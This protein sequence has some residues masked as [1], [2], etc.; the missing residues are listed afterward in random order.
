M[1]TKAQPAE[2]GPAGHRVFHTMDGLRGVAA[3]MV[4]S[5]HTGDWFKHA[6]P[7]SSYLAVDLFFA[8]SGFVISLSYEGRLK[9]GLGLWPFL[10]IRLIRLY[11][12]YLLGTVIALVA[13][14]AAAGDG[15]PARTLLGGLPA[16]LMLP[17]L[18]F[19]LDRPVYPMNLPAWSL[20]AELLV[21]AAFA[22]LVSSFSNRVL[23]IGLAVSAAGLVAVGVHYQ[24]LAIGSDA[25]SFLP[26]LLRTAYAFMA[27]MAAYRL[28]A[29]GRWRLPAA[30]SMT[31]LLTVLLLALPAPASWRLPYDLACALVLLPAIVAMAAGSEPGSRLAAV[32]SQLGGV[33]YAI[34]T[35]HVPIYDA[36]KRLG[37]RSHGLAA[38]PPPLSGALFLLVLLGLGFAADACFDRPVRRWLSRRYRK[39]TDS[40]G[41]AAT[42]TTPASRASR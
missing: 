25:G 4:V 36:L 40:Q 26:S 30:P 35:I 1:V 37:S 31:V 12:L 7:A 17:D 23:A 14:F 10:R 32:F 6:R 29:A 28:T 21:N 18:A 38:L 2:A 39:P 19:Q 13:A 9:A 5:W 3:L 22:A 42:S 16:L 34:Y 8:L 15:R 20:L 24:S 33:S 27:G 41:Q 11:P